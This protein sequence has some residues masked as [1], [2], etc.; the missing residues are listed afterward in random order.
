MNMMRITLLGTAAAEAIPAPFCECETC[1]HARE[2]KGKNIRKRAA[3]VINNDMVVDWGPDLVSACSELGLSLS[4]VKY[5]LVSHNHLDHIL[6]QNLKLRQEMFRKN[7]L[8]MLTFIAVPSVMTMLTQ[9]GATDAQMALQRVPLL[10]FDS[11]KLPDYNIS[12]VKAEHAPLVGDAVNFILDDGRTKILIASDTGYYK[13]PTWD[14]LKGQRF[15]L[16]IMENTMGELEAGSQY[17]LNLKDL[18]R[19]SE[20]M[21]EIGAVTKK[22]ILVATHFSHHYV[23]SHEVLEQKLGKHGIRCAYDGMM[24]EV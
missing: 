13:E 14:A 12:S 17:H 18:I 16:V 5:G 15:D 1:R 9:S 23:P 6:P 4:G 24:L 7:N 22:T 2:H 3:Y 20:K 10:P 8:P 11:M 19:M 21:K